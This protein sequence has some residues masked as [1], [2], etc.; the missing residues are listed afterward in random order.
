MRFKTITT[1]EESIFDTI[2]DAGSIPA[3]STNKKEELSLKAEFFFFIGGG[4]PV[5]YA[6]Q[7]QFAAERRIH[8]TYGNQ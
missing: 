5:E 8:Q 3:T 4:L 1:L 7:T 2:L 6:K